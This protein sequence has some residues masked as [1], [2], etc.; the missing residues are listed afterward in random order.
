MV[1]IVCGIR[2]DP[3]KNDAHADI[4][5]IE[6]SP[7]TVRVI[8][9]NEDLMIARHTRDLLFRERQGGVVSVEFEN[10]EKLLQA[11]KNL[12]AMPIAVIDADELHVFW[13]GPARL[14]RQ[15]ISIL[16]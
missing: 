8:H 12:P 3:G 16:F 15:G 6:N 5:S 10:F 2:L 14:P 13:K 4:I 9:T 11:V 1:W 7:C